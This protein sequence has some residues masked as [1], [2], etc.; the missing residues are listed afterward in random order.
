[1]R[2]VMGRV[3]PVEALGTAVGEPVAQAVQ[4][5]GP[6]EVGRAEAA[7]PAEVLAA[8]DR[9]GPE[10]EPGRGSEATAVAPVGR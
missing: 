2:G 9:L 5:E 7:G 10:A 1:M 4:A 6:E 3:L 8:E